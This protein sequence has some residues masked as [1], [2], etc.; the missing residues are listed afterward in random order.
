MFNVP[1]LIIL[2][3]KVEA[4]HNLFQILKELKPAKLY[5]AADGAIPGD[6]MDYAYCLQTRNVILPHW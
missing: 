5:V 3:N 6:R 2:Y 4:V 1:I